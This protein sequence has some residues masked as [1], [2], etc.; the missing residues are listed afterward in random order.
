M[1]VKSGIFV[2][3]YK[4]EEVYVFSTP[5]F[6]EPYPSYEGCKVVK[7]LMDYINPRAWYATLSTFLEK[8]GYRRVK[9]KTDGIFIS[10][11]KY[12]ADMLK[13]FDLASVKTAITPMETKIA[14]TKDKEADEVDNWSYARVNS[15]IVIINSGSLLL[16]PGKLL[17]SS[18]NMRYALTHNLTI[19]DS[20]VKQFWQTATASTLANGTLELRASIDTIEYTITEAS[21]RSKLQLADALGISMLPNT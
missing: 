1:E 15:G 21:V 18:D 14:L 5:R 3:H 19:H 8:H 20:L 6:V 11:D 4:I 10:Q 16:N 9:Q 12:V 7:A 13:K 2:W 17:V